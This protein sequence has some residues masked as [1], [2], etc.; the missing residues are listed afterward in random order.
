M[1]QTITTVIGENSVE[2]R[3]EKDSDGFQILRINGLCN[4]E[5]ILKKSFLDE[6]K[7]ALEMADLSDESDFS[8]AFEYEEGR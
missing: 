4:P 2:I 8:G 3:F 7:E 5:L 6:C 1:I